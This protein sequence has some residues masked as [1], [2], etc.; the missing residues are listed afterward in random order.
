MKKRISMLL[1]AAV[2]TAALPAACMAETESKVADASEMTT[3]ED[4]VEEGMVPIEADQL[5]EGSYPVEV[6]SSSSMFHIDS[7]I[8]TVKEDGMSCVMVMGGTGYLYVY[9]GTGEE[10]AAAPEEDYI[11][12]VEN[13]S[14]AHTFTIPVEALDKGLDLA[15]FSKKKEKWYERTIL[16]RA[17]SLPA[18]AF[19]EM[20]LVTAADLGLEDGEYTI[21]VA[22]E[23][24][25][26]KA[27]VETPAKLVIKDGEAT[28]TIVFS[29]KNY[30]YMLVNDEKYLKTNEEGN[31]TFEIPVSGFDYKMPVVADTVAMSTPHEISYKLTFDSATITPAA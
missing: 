8:L 7:A 21:E 12:Y 9:P 11:P 6:K 10:A 13:A 31:S 24:G 29:S 2:V 15:A 5:N 23:G 19:K 4:V 27:S 26:G 25:S 16:L 18:D 14:G 3:V 1:L 22:L 17:D 20:D 28:A 30:D